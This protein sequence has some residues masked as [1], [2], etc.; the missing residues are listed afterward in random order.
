MVGHAVQL[1]HDLRRY[2]LELAAN[3][4]ERLLGTIIH[5]IPQWSA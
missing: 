3:V 1:A 4:R 2:T 5:G